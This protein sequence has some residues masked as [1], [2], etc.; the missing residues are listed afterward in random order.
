MPFND[1]IQGDFLTALMFDLELDVPRYFWTGTGQTT[2]DSNVYLP[3]PG[4]DSGVSITE[5]IEVGS[6]TSDL[7]LSGSLQ[8]FLF[9]ALNEPVQGRTARVWF[10][11]INDAEVVQ[12]RDLLFVGVI[13]KMPTVF[14]ADRQEIGIELESSLA[15]GG[16]RSALR[17]AKSD[18]FLID[19]TDGVFDF[20]PS[21]DTQEIKFGR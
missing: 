5:T 8:E 7:R 14:G 9:I 10:A 17:Y 21:L 16:R 12:S 15:G 13:S 2:V 20:L 4:F 19:P 1:D 3:L 18:Q 6:L 11:I